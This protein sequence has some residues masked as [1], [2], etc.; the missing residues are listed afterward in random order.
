MS[1][2]TDSELRQQA[3][4]RVNQ[5]MGFYIHLAVFVLVNLGLAAIN[6]IGGGQRWHLWP[7][8]GWGLGL[9]IHGFVTFASLRGDGV[10]ERMLD[11]EIERLK[12]RNRQ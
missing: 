1:D 7:L 8:A 11:A 6:L 2:K 10:R 12:Q 3:K 4:R 5:K 9:A